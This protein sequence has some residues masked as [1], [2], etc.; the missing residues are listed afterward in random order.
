[1]AANALPVELIEPIFAH[2]S[3]NGDMKNPRLSIYAFELARRCH[4]AGELIS[5]RPAP[6]SPSVL[7]G[8]LGAAERTSRPSCRLLRVLGGGDVEIRLGGV[9]RYGGEEEGDDADEGVGELWLFGE[10]GG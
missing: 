4:E 1:M 8:E 2:V 7:D 6:T 9:L 5:T 3:S 10:V